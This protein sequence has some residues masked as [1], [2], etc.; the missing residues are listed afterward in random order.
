MPKARLFVGNYSLNVRFAEPPGGRKFQS[1]MGICGFQ[2][3]C[4]GKQRLEYAFE[5]G[6]AAYLEDC[7]W[8]AQAMIE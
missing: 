7:D 6:E 4:L 1:L 2:V 8:Q 3:E 5:P